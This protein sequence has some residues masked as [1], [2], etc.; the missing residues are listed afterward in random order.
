MIELLPDELLSDLIRC[1][2]W[3]ERIKNVELVSKRWNRVAWLAGWTDVNE[4]DNQHMEEKEASR[5]YGHRQHFNNQT[6][7]N[8]AGKW[9]SQPLRS[10]SPGVD[11]SFI[12]LPGP[13]MAFDPTLPK[14]PT[15]PTL[16]DIP[17]EQHNVGPH[18][19]V[20]ARWVVFV[21]ARQV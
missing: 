20:I 16:Q 9:V 19:E 18:S 13:P 2:P 21:R 14:C 5:N 3:K 6:L 10:P 11:S 1:L 4:F 7:I 15:S 8:I 12:G 17:P